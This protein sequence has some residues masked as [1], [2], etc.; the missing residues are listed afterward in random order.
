MDRRKFSVSLISMASLAACGGGG[1]S[2]S[3]FA[4]LPVIAPEPQPVPATTPTPEPTVPT[5][6]ELASP[7]ALAA[8]L[9]FG[10]TVPMVGTSP[11]PAFAPMQVNVWDFNEGFAV[12]DGGA[13]QFD[14]ALQ[15][16]VEVA[17]SSAGAVTWMPE[18]Q[19]YDELRAFGPEF[20]AADGV[21]AV[22]FTDEPTFLDNQ[23]MRSQGA[24]VTAAFLHMGSPVTLSQPLTGLTSAVG[25]LTLSWGAIAAANI[26]SLWATAV[27]TYFR[28]VLRD[29][30]GT[31]LETCY[32]TT[33]DG[34]SGTWGNFDLPDRYRQ[35]PTIGP[36]SL[37][38][39]QWGGIGSVRG[40]PIKD[41]SVSDG[42]TEFVRNAEFAN[43]GEH[44]VV[45]GDRASQNLR[46]GTRTLE[47]LDV[48]R[49]F[50]TEPTKLWGRMTDEFTNR[51]G[52]P[53][54][55]T[56]HYLTNLGSDAYGVIY[57]T[58]GA[59]TKA[60]GTWDGASFDR[61]SGWV[62]GNA[63]QVTFTSV[64][65]KGASDGS[66]DITVSFD[67]TVPAGGTVTLANFLLLSGATTGV[68]ALDI[69]ARCTLIDEEAVK[70]ANNF[71]TDVSYQ[72]GMTQLQL[73]TLQNF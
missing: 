49:M 5:L 46:S 45:T 48:T 61:D 69:T 64:T 66:G 9:V 60:L 51:T 57:P 22:S 37:S 30:S 28:V 40:T 33:P 67:I 56:V 42:T 73:D 38:F 36:V 53:I 70:I 1:S 32:E 59:E 20:G 62:H 21:K 71:R 2:G 12:Y 15:L 29:A 27:A 68:D 43:N 55:A 41:V 26:R 58:A 13:D 17:G 31:L 65:T 47:G 16:G 19:R 7:S 72:R 54:T 11:Q 44:W 23:G 10:Q 3:G 35:D 24:P 63:K 39:E 4:G 34:T 50:Y 8:P 6:P 52:A 18:D 25:P 14:G